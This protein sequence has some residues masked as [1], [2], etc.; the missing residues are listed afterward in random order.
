MWCIPRRNFQWASLSC[1][2]KALTVQF[3][4]GWERNDPGV[5]R[6]IYIYIR[7]YIYMI[8]HVNHIVNHYVSVYMYL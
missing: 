3:D 2:A 7:I 8:V 6:L 4:S 5:M 1:L